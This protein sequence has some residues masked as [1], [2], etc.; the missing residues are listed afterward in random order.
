VAVIWVGPD[1]MV[2]ETCGS[3]EETTV[4]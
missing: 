4:Y 3:K 1:P 2:K